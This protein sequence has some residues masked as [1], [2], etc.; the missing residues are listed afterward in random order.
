MGKPLKSKG[1]LSRL[2][3]RADQPARLPRH[4][5]PPAGGRGGG[6]VGAKPARASGV[7]HPLTRH[8]CI[9]A[10]R[11]FFYPHSEGAFLRGVNSDDGVFA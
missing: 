9:W 10:C 2:I 11:N 4:R 6:G 3:D 5:P 7:L 1:R 8:L